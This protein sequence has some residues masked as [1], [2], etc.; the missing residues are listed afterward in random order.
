MVTKLTACVE[1]T[2]QD[3]VQKPNWTEMATS[4]HYSI[5]SY[6]NKFD[7]SKMEVWPEYIAVVL[8]FLGLQSVV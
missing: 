3:R 7:Y 5:A 6:P 1:W 8:L 2:E 4:D